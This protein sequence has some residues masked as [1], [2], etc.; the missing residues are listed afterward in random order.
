MTASTVVEL[1]NIYLTSDQGESVFSNL[2]F[3]LGAGRSAWIAGASG[4]GKTS[5]VRLIVARR[6]PDSGSVEVLGCPLNPPRRR[7]VNRVRRQIGGVG[8]IYSLI[9]S[10]TVAQNV[11]FPLTLGHH[12]RRARHERL[13]KTLAEFSLV[14]LAGKYPQA[15]TRV[16][17]T[18]VQFARATVA[19]QPLLLVD[20]PLAGLDVQTYRSI[21][22][23]LVRVI[24]SGCSM[25]VVAA[26]PPQPA[27]PS[28]DCFRLENGVLVS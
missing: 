10:M 24:L 20:E 15:L 13:L 7:L 14:K 25:I 23:H 28:T 21:Y 22:D 1:S 17:Q 26:E 4:S 9:P 12:R 11:A 19:S 6:S 3:R 16:Q 18:L 27:L 5:L 2:S 8:G